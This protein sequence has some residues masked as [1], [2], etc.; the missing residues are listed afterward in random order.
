[1][2]RENHEG[3]ITDACNQSIYQEQ[4]HT[5]QAIKYVSE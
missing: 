3:N 4:T 2:N 1:M 5:R